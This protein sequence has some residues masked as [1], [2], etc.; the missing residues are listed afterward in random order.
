MNERQYEIAIV[1]AGPAGLTAAL[2][3]GRA[4]KRTVL[5]EAGIPGGELLNTED[6][7]DYPG[8]ESIKGP[9]LAETMTK[10]A[11]KFGAEMVTARVA[12]ITP[13]PDGLKR[14]ELE[15]GEP[16]LAEAVIITAG[17]HPR[18]LEVPGEEEFA[19]RGVSYCAVCDGAFFK[20]QHLAV[21]GGGDAAIEEATFL[22]RYASE[23]TVVHRRE[24]F[25][26]QP[27]LVERAR[28]NGQIDFLLDRVVEEIKGR[29]GRV[30]SV[31]LRHLPSDQPESLM[32]GGVFIFVGF[33]PNTGLLAVHAEHDPQGYYLTDANMMT[34]VSGV[35]AAGDV[36]SQLTRQV[37]TA[38][39]D[40]T[41]AAIAATKQVEE[42]RAARDSAVPIPV[43]G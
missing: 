21:I 14:I 22:T 35:Y 26:A 12:S 23:V 16:Y 43:G 15:E 18:K 33:L 8:F 38:V 6:V 27:L 32:V 31:Q 34:S 10:H 42:E 4:L 29:D 1:G 3:A 39:G 25:R 13:Q 41:T 24:E 40:A 37:T 5:L 2:Y 7:E 36:R 30:E 28:Q 11:L 19:G 20:G 17:G 9:E